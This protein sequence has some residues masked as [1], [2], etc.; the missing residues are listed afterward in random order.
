[1]TFE[2]TIA[3]MEAPERDENPL[4]FR[5]DEEIAYWL[6]RNSETLTDRIEPQPNKWLDSN[7]G[8]RL[9]RSA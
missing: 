1:M 8:D 5:H 9:H 2:D 4:I 3:L 6:C 7:V